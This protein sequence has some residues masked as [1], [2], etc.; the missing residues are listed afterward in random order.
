MYI[1]SNLFSDCIECMA[2]SDNVVRAGLTPKL[3]D[4]PTL[5]EM[6]DYSSYT[7]DQLL[8]CPQMVDSNSCIWRPPVPDFAVVKIRVRMCC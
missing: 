7:L 2:C 5:V 1:T 6:L 3:I 8:F 4:V